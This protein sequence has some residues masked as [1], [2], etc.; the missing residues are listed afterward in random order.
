MSG[1]FAQ[2]DGHLGTPGECRHREAVY[3]QLSS[4][5]M[6]EAHDLL[7]LATAA[8]RAL[9][10]PEARRDGLL[11]GMIRSCVAV[12]EAE[13]RSRLA[14]QRRAEHQQAE[15]D[16]APAVGWQAAAQ[17]APPV[18]DKARI[19]STFERMRREYDDRL[20]HF[21]L[22]RARDW[23]TKLQEL[24]ASHPLFISSAALERCRI[25]LTR[26]EQRAGQLSVEIEELAMSAVQ[27][28]AEGKVEIAAQALKRL[29][30]MQAARPRLFPNDRL[31]QIRQ[32]IAEAGE[33]FEHREAGEAL[34]ARERA[35]AD[36]IRKLADGVHRFH[37]IAREVPHCEPTYLQAEAEYRKAVREVRHHDREWLADLMI[38]LN[39]KLEALHDPTGRAEEQVN[40][41]IASVRHALNH[42]IQEI[43][44]IA[45]ENATDSP[46]ST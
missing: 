25:D 37:R 20:V 40:R 16:W 7:T 15:R 27:S 23:L 1:R 11:A 45:A 5:I 2:S 8:S 32:S 31:Q 14:E 41:F 12:R 38:E 46:R 29:S 36:E 34:V 39:D 18:P 26:V 35:V 17:P 22:E 3:Q 6:R 30:S 24:Q 13:L 44:E 4:D 21:E 42:M 33:N 19:V 9:G 10:H 28:A 43:R